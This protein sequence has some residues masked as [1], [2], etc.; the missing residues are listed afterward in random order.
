MLGAPGAGKGTQASRLASDFGVPHVSTGDMLRDGIR[1]GLAVAL[2]ARAT[3]DRGELVDDATMI[4]IVQ[5]RL[6]RD[7]ARRGVVLDGFPRTVSQARALDALAETDD[8]GALV[9][10]ELNVPAGVL[11]ERL[12]SRRVCADCGRGQ[13]PPAVATGLCQQCGGRLLQRQDDREDVI[14]ERLAV[15]ERSTRPLVNYYRGRPTFGA[16]N[17]DQPLATVSRELQRMVRSLSGNAALVG[18][19]V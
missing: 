17:G 12:T 9:V 15:Y 8:M 3:I 1:R 18:A 10:V 13:E 4:A 19:G 11:I 6:A 14:R 16:V 5:E 7:D 2:E